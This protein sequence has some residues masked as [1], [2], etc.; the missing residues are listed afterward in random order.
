MMKMN[1]Y[2][3]AI[4]NLKHEKLLLL[5]FLL[6]LLCCDDLSVKVCFCNDAHD[7]TTLG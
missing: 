4:K 3:I 5:F 6:W 2:L 1:E 7:A